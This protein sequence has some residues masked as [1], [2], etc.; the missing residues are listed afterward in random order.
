MLSHARKLTVH[1]NNIPY[2]ESKIKFYVQI[3]QKHPCITKQQIQYIII[4]PMTMWT[5]LSHW[6]QDMYMKKA[7]MVNEVYSYTKLWTIS[8]CAFAKMC[9]DGLKAPSKAFQLNHSRWPV[10]VV[11][12]YISHI[13]MHYFSHTCLKV[14]CPFNCIATLL[15]NVNFNTDGGYS[16]PVAPFIHF[17]FSKPHILYLWYDMMTVRLFILGK[18]KGRA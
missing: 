6:M 1:P 15:R 2:R 13:K 18:F 16:R 9:W 10:P 4:N 17:L 12:I 8:H 14:K 11:I 7:K 5:L 3:L